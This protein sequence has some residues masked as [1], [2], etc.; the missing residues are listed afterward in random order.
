MKI[1]GIIYIVISAILFGIT[2]I[3]C[4]KT[5]SMGNDPF[6]L[7]FQRNLFAIPILTIVYIISMK[8]RNLSFKTK[9]FKDLAITAIIGTALTPLLLYSSYEYLG[10]GAATTIHFMYPLFVT[11]I[12][13]LF[14]KDKISKYQIVCLAVATIGVLLFMDFKSSG[15]L[16]GIIISVLSAV[17]FAMY[18]VFMEKK[19]LAQL[20]PLIN[21]LY[22]ALISAVF[23]AI[24][25]AITGKLKLNLPISL[26]LYVAAIAFFTSFL[27]VVLIQKGIG[28]IGSSLSAIFSLLEPITSIIFSALFLGERFTLMK[29]IACSLILISILALVLVSFK[30]H[31]NQSN[32]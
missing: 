2:P 22:L 13:I 20:N 6:N 18:M 25:G 32:I 5:Y 23:F 15:S 29:V 1:K 8:G 10:V 16:L 17:T 24:T 19:G 12:C 28:I 4:S 21:S 30:E 7:V 3:M 9:R 31:R 11:L 27:G 14:F 26:Y